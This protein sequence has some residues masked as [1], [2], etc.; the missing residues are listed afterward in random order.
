MDL[1]IILSDWI[2]NNKQNFCVKKDG[3]VMHCST[4]QLEWTPE[5]DQPR[6]KIFYNTFDKRVL[7]D[8]KNRK[9]QHQYDIN[10]FEFS[11]IPKKVKFSNTESPN[12]KDIEELQQAYNWINLK[13]DRTTYSFK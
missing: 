6:F 2:K 1:H 5:P 3:F 7:Y 8:T 4:Q 11:K 13:G 12:S 10:S 9:I